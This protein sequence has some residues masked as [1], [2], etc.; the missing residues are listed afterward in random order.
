MFEQKPGRH[1]T[2]CQGPW[3]EASRRLPRAGRNERL[4]AFTRTQIHANPHVDDLYAVSRHGKGQRRPR[5]PV[6]DLDGIDPVP[7]GDFAGR[8]QKIDRGGD[9]PAIVI[10]RISKRLA[11]VPTLWVRFQFQYPDDLSSSHSQNQTSKKG[12]N[13]RFHRLRKLACDVISH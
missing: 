6:P 7:M 12:I 11:I 10:H 3:S 9:G 13:H 4:R 5:V 8:Q 2:A 1:G